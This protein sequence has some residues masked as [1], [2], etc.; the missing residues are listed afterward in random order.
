MSSSKKSLNFR[1]MPT[2]NKI[3]RIF[4]DLSNLME[5]NSVWDLLARVW[6][7]E[8]LEVNFQKSIFKINFET[9]IFKSQF[10]KFN[11][12]K[13]LLKLSRVKPMFFAPRV[14][15][16]KYRTE[17]PR[18]FSPISN[19]RLPIFALHLARAQAKH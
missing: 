19:L 5:P 6:K 12:K 11:T 14:I 15:T 9:S 3:V 4:S 17:S 1:E 16:E 7:S 10:S 13:P 8:F 18:L 2:E